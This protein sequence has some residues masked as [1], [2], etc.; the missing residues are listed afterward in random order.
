M[1]LPMLLRLTLICFA[2]ILT[3]PITIAAEHGAKPA[4]GAKP[5][6]EKKPEPE[7]LFASKDNLVP[8]PTIIAPVVLRSDGRLTGHLYFQLAAL[9]TTAGE[10]N[11]VKQ[12]LPYVQD[13]LLREVY[14][15]ILI[16]DDLKAIPDS[17]ALIARLKDSANAA[18]GKPVI[19]EMEIGRIDSAPY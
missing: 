13:A 5:K 10:A 15:S 12:R 3:A 11:E 6:E 7:G 8:L 1:L 14:H 4:H 2:I 16:V 18:V 17:K 19:T 9:T